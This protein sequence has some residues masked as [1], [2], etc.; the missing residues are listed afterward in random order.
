MYLDKEDQVVPACPDEAAGLYIQAQSGERV[1]VRLPP[2]TCG[3]QIGE[4]S[5]IQSGG[6]CKRH[7]TPAERLR[8]GPF[9]YSSS[10]SLTRHW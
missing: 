5:Q 9:P 7:L 3:F 10:L 6:L 8:A 2:D 1:Q 4:T